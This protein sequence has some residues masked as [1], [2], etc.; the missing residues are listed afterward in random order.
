MLFDLCAA[1]PFTVISHQ[2]PPKIIQSHSVSAVSQTMSQDSRCSIS[3][4]A[5]ML[6]SFGLGAEPHPNCTVEGGV[7][8]AKDG[9]CIAVRLA[10]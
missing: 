10:R 8:K 3:L 4:A 5:L 1:R 7:D 6:W 9:V 2:N